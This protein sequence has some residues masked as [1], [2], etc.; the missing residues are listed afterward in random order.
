MRCRRSA[1]KVCWVNLQGCWMPD[2]ELDDTP[3]L[4]PRRGGRR[5]FDL[6]EA[7]IHEARAKETPN[8]AYHCLDLR[9]LLSQTMW[10]ASFDL[11]TNFFTSLGYFDDEAEHEAVVNGFV[12]V[13]KP[14]GKLLV[15]FLNVPQVEANL[16]TSETVSKKG[17]MFH[18][19]RRI[20]EG[21][22]EKSIQFEWEGRPQHHVERVRALDRS[23]LTALL[24]RLGLEV[25]HIWGDYDLNEW[26]SSSPRCMILA[27][28][29]TTST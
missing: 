8:I 4:W 20:H 6:S 1:R 22:I 13:L 26:T 5:G 7:S 28:L 9:D 25:R 14:G 27:E 2:V 24:M 12:N 21:W 19:H 10:H 3:G 23:H 18:I 15:D 11:V 29:P 16:I 17:T